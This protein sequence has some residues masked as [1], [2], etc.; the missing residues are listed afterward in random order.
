MRAPIF[1]KINPP[2]GQ[3]GGENRKPYPASIAILGFSLFL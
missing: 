2:F 1:P 3:E